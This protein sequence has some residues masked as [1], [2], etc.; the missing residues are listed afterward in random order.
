MPLA[1]RVDVKTERLLLRLARKRGET[2]SEI[3]R[4]AIG[5]LAKEVHVQ[6]ATEYPYEKVRDII[7]SVSEGPAD[8]SMKT[9]EKFRRSLA[10]RPG[11][12]G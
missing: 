12:P 1:V 8:L 5:V 2:K 7:G 9:G 10:G 3:I 6:E 4:E 11:K